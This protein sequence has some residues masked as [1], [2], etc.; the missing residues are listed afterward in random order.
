V[1]LPQRETLEAVGAAGTKEEGVT[2][3]DA[4]TRADTQSVSKFRD[5]T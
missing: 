3:A 2:E 4:G 5:R 1:P